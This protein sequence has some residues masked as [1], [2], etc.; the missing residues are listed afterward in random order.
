MHARFAGRRVPATVVEARANAPL[1][2]LD[3]L[4]VLDLDAVERAARSA[5]AARRVDHPGAVHDAGAIDGGR[6]DTLID[7]PQG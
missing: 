4:L 5:A 7:K 1:H 3:D 2:L 6:D